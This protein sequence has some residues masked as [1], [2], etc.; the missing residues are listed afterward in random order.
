MSFRFPLILTVVVAILA[1]IALSWLK[2]QEGGQNQGKAKA[3]AKK[4]VPDTSHLPPRE[5]EWGDGTR[6]LIVGGHASHDFD[7]WF[8]QEDTK[9]LMEDGDYSIFYTD[10]PQ[11]IPPA[12]EHVDVLYLSLN[13]KPINLRVQKAIEAF[14]DGGGGLL[15]VH[16]AVW[17]NWND[18][19]TYYDRFVG[20]F[21]KGHDKLGPFTV[22][23]IDTD[24]PVTEGFASSFEVTDELYYHNVAPEATGVHVLAEATSKQ[25]KGT[26]PTVW[27]VEHPEARI[28]CMTLGHDGDTHT[29]DEYKTL[30][31][32]AVKWVTPEK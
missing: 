5:F 22:E 2:A 30:L 25:G 4:V 29:Q 14:V 16:A 18:W 8:D 31:R 12:L 11:D 19:P 10:R 17:S 13:Q 23:V 21:S 28:F 7:R 1:G 20:G 32:R 24:H 9:T 3:K 15:L 26:R 6:V 27:T